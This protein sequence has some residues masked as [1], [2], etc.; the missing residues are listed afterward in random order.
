MTQFKITH[1]ELVG[2]VQDI[3]AAACKALP[4]GRRYRY[5][6]A[7]VHTLEDGRKVGTT[8]R[9]QTKPKLQ[10]RITKRHSEIAQG[11]LAAEFDAAGEYSGTV[12]MLYIS[13]PL[14]ALRHHVSG[15]VERGEQAPITG[16]PA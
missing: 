12:L 7:G 3:G 8:V 13:P 2:D 6:Q 11:Q 5:K 14:Q 15:A 4:P 10:E 16:I 1:L 9:A